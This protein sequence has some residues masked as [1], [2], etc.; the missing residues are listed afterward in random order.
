MLRIGGSFSGFAEA[1]KAITVKYGWKHV[2]LVSIY[3]NG[4]AL[5]WFGAKPFLELI[6]LDSNYTFT[7]LRLG[8]QPT[9]EQLLK[10]LEKIRALARGL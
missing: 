10:T 7:W 1:F 3:D 8:P 2:V 9:D 5:C 4:T 6:G